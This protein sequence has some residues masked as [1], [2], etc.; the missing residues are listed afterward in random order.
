MGMLP[1]EP[2]KVKG[3][4][5]TFGVTQGPLPTPSSSHRIIRPKYMGFWA[6]LSP[7]FEEKF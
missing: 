4:I 1:M 7:Y 2:K 6:H 3:A 5:T